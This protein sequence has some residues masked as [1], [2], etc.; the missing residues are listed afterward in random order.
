MDKPDF[1]YHASPHRN[2]QLFEP[3]NDTP[4][5]PGEPPLVFATGDKR[6]AAMFLA[7][8]SSGSVE[9]TKFGDDAIII[10][11]N[12]VEDFIAHDTGGAIYHLPAD[13]FTTDPEIGMGEQEWVSSLPVAPIGKELYGT[14]LGAMLSVGVKVYFVTDEVLESIKS[15]EDHGFEIIS[16]LHPY[17]PEADI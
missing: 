3:R 1:L 9:V 12:T 5:F 6:I 15:A 17:E 7:P 8:K 13:T 10:I 16:S 2:I 4:R 11:S 14:S